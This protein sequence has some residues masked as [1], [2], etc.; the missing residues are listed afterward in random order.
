MTLKNKRKT[1]IIAGTLFLV[2]VLRLLQPLFS[3]NNNC[4]TEKSK[5]QKNESSFPSQSDEIL[6]EEQDDLNDTNYFKEVFFF[7]DTYFLQYKYELRLLNL[8]GFL[9]YRTTKIKR[10]IFITLNTIR[11]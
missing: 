3:N 10:K 4:F 11:I 5:I 2:F 1:N 8:K 7:L 6:V 9:D